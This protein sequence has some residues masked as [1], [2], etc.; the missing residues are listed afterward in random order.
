MEPIVAQL[1]Q[2]PDADQQ[3]AGHADGQAR[4]VDEGVPLMLEDIPQGYDD[5]VLDHEDLSRNM[6]SIFLVIRITMASVALRFTH[7][8]KDAEDT[9]RV[10]KARH[11]HD[12]GRK[13]E[14]E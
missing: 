6:S 12:A 10:G 7:I 9:G 13:E 8:T 14:A 5:V 11:F 2:D 3:A 1:I 4:D